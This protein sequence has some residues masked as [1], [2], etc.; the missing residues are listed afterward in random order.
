MNYFL[1]TNVISNLVVIVSLSIDTV[2]C[3]DFMIKAYQQNMTG[4]DYVYIMPVSL[5]VAMGTKMPWEQGGG[6]D[7][8][9]RAAFKQVFESRV[10]ATTN[11]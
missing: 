4:P 5:T 6:K 9:V 10:I 8:M 1:K 3:R 11:V 2:G 7:D